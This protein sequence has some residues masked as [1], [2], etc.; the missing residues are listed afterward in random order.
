MDSISRIT[1]QYSEVEDRIRLSGELPD[2][3]AVVFWMTHRLVARLVPVLANWLEKQTG[4]LPMPEV[5][6]E[7]AQQAA[8]AGMTSQPP[9]E[10]PACSNIVLVESVDLRFSD[11]AA[12]VTFKYGN[13]QAAYLLLNPVALRQWLGILRR[14]FERGGWSLDIWPEWSRIA[15]APKENPQ[16]VMLH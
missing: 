1:T 15:P 4:D 16:G 11:E 9:V 2:E 6:Q 7:M 12:R 13:E 10:A 3:T 8:E 14:A 5:R